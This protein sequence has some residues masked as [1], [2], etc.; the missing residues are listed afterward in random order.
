[1]YIREYVIFFRIG[2]LIKLF[3]HIFRTDACYSKTKRFLLDLEYFS[4]LLL[5]HNE[6]RIL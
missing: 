3:S 5:Y 4:K 6:K 2:S 1:M